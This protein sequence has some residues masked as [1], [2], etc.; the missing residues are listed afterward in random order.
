MIRLVPIKITSLTYLK[1]N[2]MESHYFKLIC[3]LVFYFTNLL[4]AQKDDHGIKIEPVPTKYLSWEDVKKETN[5]KIFKNIE[6]DGFIKFEGSGDFPNITL[7]ESKESLKYARVFRSVTVDADSLMP[8]IHAK[9]NKSKE[10]WNYLDG[11]YVKIIANY[12]DQEKGL[13]Y[14]SMGRLTEIRILKISNNGS[15]FEIVR[16]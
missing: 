16:K 10:S 2:N 9:Y 15:D 13:D 1:A 14:I 3:I 4:H 5:G 8:L 6:I 11:L 12:K 7:W